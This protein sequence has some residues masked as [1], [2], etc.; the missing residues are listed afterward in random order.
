VCDP[1][2]AWVRAGPEAWADGAVTL[3]ARRGGRYVLPGPGLAVTDPL[4]LLAGRT[5]PRAPHVLLA[6]P[7]FFT[8]DDFTV[9]LGRRYQPGGIPLSSSTGEAIEFVGTRDYRHG[10]PVPPIHWPSWAPPRPP[11][12]TTF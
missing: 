2:E 9:P 7:P 10:A 1:A 12:L 11:L 4:G 6:H 3:G 5:T 8:L